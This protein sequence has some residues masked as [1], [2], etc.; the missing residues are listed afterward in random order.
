M[1]IYFSTILLFLCSSIF[2][3]TA[4][5]K[6]TI[7]DT[8]FTSVI[9]TP[10]LNTKIIDLKKEF[11]PKNGVFQFEIDVTQPSL[12][13]L[14]YRDQYLSLYIT[15]NSTIEL[16]LDRTLQEK[17]TEF[18]G[19]HLK[20]N[21]YLNSKTNASL[22]SKEQRE[23]YKSI[24]IKSSPEEYK[25]FI[26]QQLDS[27]KEAFNK[28]ADSNQFNQ[29]FSKLY[30]NNYLISNSYQL[31]FL[32]P[33]FLKLNSDSFFINN[34]SYLEFF[35]TIPKT[36]E[37]L[38]C[39]AYLETQILY[40]KTITEITDFKNMA[41]DSID[42]IQFY[43]TLVKN[44]T[45]IN[46]SELRTLMI[47]SLIGEY[48]AYYGLPTDIKEEIRDYVASITDTYKSDMVKKK[49][50]A[51]AA[52]DS[53]KSAPLFSFT[54]NSGNIRQLKEFVGKV[55][56][57]D[58]WASW[59]G[60][61]KAEIPHSKELVELYK[62]RKDIVFLYISIDDVKT[63]WEKSLIEHKLYMGVQGIAYPNGF[64]S[65]F[66][67]KYQV[68]AI[69]HYVLIDKSGNLIA[70]KA[71]RPSQKEKIISLLNKALGIK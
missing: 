4:I 9:L 15:P 48:I 63:N 10:S 27:K 41:E 17:T 43:K 12:Y 65:D 38:N 64:N 18:K 16:N 23:L 57:M 24:A 26:D 7:K 1:K 30:I 49:L 45:K 54:D 2:S 13:R 68:Q 11:H 29:D 36:K 37:F 14:N 55:V 70:A 42:E 28:T 67:K 31:K 35:N 21:D 22:T 69:P 25:T 3:N 44:A 33:K 34:S 8:A 56:Y 32:Y 19:S 40:L 50:L 59:C 62:N 5:V 66:A 51:L 6:G 39:P 52:Y 60:P 58:I 71:N 53:G 20:E 46:S 47:E 61:C